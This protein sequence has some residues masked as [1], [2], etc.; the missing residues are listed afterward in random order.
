[1]GTVTHMQAHDDT[2]PPASPALRDDHVLYEARRKW[3]DADKARARH[4]A[5]MVTRD[6]ALQ[7]AMD[8]GWTSRE[9]A[10][11]VGVRAINIRNML[12]RRRKGDS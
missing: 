8:N 10:E 1:M 11:A 7:A 6:A 12:S 2:T 9:I 4:E 5:A 3:R